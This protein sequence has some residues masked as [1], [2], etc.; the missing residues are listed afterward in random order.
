MSNA[1]LD[2]T[3]STIVMHVLLKCRSFIASCALAV[4]LHLASHWNK[5]VQSDRTW[6]L[7]NVHA[8]VPQWCS[9]MAPSMTVTH[10]CD[11]SFTNIHCF[12]EAVQVD[13]WLVQT[14]CSVLCSVLTSSIHWIS[15][16]VLGERPCLQPYAICTIYMLASGVPAYHPSNVSW[17]SWL[18]L[19]AKMPCQNA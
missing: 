5:E 19:T 13:V 8:E 3:W 6:V 11:H 18:L 15:A 9:S 1:L 7:W 17:C 14:G 16:N 10:K 12:G 2:N 4:L